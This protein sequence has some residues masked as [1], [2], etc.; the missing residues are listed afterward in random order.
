LTWIGLH[1]KPSEKKIQPKI[2]I[3]AC[4]IVHIT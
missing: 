1:Q 4:R 3:N 2:R